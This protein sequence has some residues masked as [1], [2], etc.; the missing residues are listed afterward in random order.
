MKTTRRAWIGLAVIALPCVL[1]AMDLTVLNLAVPKLAEQLRPTSTELLWILDIY[2]F[3]VAGMLIPMGTLGDRIGRR[4]L[5]LAGAAAFG[6]VSVVAAFAPTAKA[7]IVSRALLGLAGATLAPSTLSL[8]RT[9]FEHERERSL[10]IGI[11]IASYSV[12]SAIGPLVG[13]V[14]LAHFWPGAVFLLGVPVMALLLALGPFLLPEVRDPDPAPTDWRGALLSLGSV[15]LVIYGIKRA[16]A[17]GFSPPALLAIVLGAVGGALYVRR[18]SIAAQLFRTPAFRAS[19]AAYTLATF[20]AFGVYVLAAQ[21]LQVVLGLTPLAA[22]VATMP[23]AVAFIVG[24]LLTS[25][26]TSRL[27]RA[28][29]IAGGLAVAA[30]GFAILARGGVHAIVIGSALESLGCAP[31]FTLATE[32]VVGS[33]PPERAGVAAAISETGSELGGALGIAILG[34]V[35]TAVMR[36]DSFTAALRVCATIA[37]CIVLGVA[38][39]TLRSHRTRAFVRAS[40]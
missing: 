34:S 18:R 8:I 12:G 29:V 22:G 14:V 6:V 7:L 27:E 13:G 39:H 21:Y 31:V 33:V 28:H 3:L 15:L 17:D 4:R 5:L 40:A 2:G 10:A 16:A 35:A 23:F 30:L 9:M 36:H 38:V 11:W 25:R 1:Y 26:L 32:L 19:F 20:A 24:S 37:A